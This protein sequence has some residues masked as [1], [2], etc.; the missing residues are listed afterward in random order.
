MTTAADD[1]V[2]HIVIP[3]CE[4]HAGV[5]AIHA[6]VSWLDGLPPRRPTGVAAL[7]Q[8]SSFICRVS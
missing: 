8:H 5:S 1:S 6:D 7:E 3:A 4:E 2:R